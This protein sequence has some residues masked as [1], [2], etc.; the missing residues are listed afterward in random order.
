MMNNIKITRIKRLL[1][2]LLISFGFARLAVGQ[3]ATSN[4][5]TTNSPF[6]RYLQNPPWI[7]EMRYVQ[8]M[9]CA[10][11]PAPGKIEEQ[12]WIDDTNCFALQPN[13]MFYEEYTGSP[14]G[15][16]RP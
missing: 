16:P 5:L 7:K 1:V 2:C 3:E 13:G 15:P 14:F 8:S 11:G 6:V 9:Y 10:A 12:T 4:L